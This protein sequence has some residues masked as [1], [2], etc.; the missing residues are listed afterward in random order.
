M[1][2]GAVIERRAMVVAYKSDL[3]SSAT[4][5]DAPLLAFVSPERLQQNFTGASTAN[6]GRLPTKKYM[7]KLGFTWDERRI[8]SSLSDAD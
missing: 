4:T 6:M 7:R 2:R 3:T 5:G 8:F 1:V